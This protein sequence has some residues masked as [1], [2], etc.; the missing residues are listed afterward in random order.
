MNLP[1]PP[2]HTTVDILYNCSD[3]LVHPINTRC[4]V[5][6]E[7]YAQLGLERRLRR[8]E[9]VRDVMNSW[10][11]DTQNSLLVMPSDAYESDRDLDEA[12]AP[13]PDEPP[14]GFILQLHHSQR[15]GKWHK[16]FVTLLESGHMY[17]AKK[18]EAGPGPADRD[19]RP[20]CH[21]SDFDIYTPTEAQMRKHL[22]PPKKYCYAVKSQQKTTLFEST[23]NFVHF[24]STEDPA[25]AHKF[26]ALVHGWRS[27]HILRRRAEVARQAQEKIERAP[28]PQITAVRHKPK[29]SVSHVKV[30]G[31]RLKVSVDESPYAIGAFQPLLDLKRFDKPIDDFG[32]DWV[33]DNGRFS[34]APPAAPKRPSRRNSSAGSRTAQSSPGKGKTVASPTASAF[35]ANGLLGE[36]YDARK[37]AAAPDNG[38]TFAILDGPFTDE[39]TLFADGPASPTSAPE[40][41]SAPPPPAEPEKPEISWFPSAVEHSAKERARAQSLRDVSRP[42]TSSGV[43]RH[44]QHHYRRPDKPPRRGGAPPRAPAPLVNLAPQWSTEGRGRGVKAPPGTHLVDLAT[45]PAAVAAA[46]FLEVPP[47]GLIRREGGPRSGAPSAPLPPPPPAGRQRSKSTSAGSGFARRG[48]ECPPVPPLPRPVTRDGT[49]GDPGFGAGRKDRGRD[50]RP[51]EFAARGRSGTLKY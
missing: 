2:E 5:V 48:D 22:K 3:S 27:W 24:F 41:P 32:K 37:T 29:K 38:A 47:R 49:G 12:A 1:V 8:Y 19:A 14:Q 23:E 34:M 30:H 13:A 28:P 33:P 40:P 10:D 21:L 4:S 35:A 11:R 46:R 45:G 31:H 20:L 39:P 26:H 15:P 16:R 50:L 18:P 43:P 25:V 17:A 42:S 9:R 36:R 6:L 51:R 44:D 7:K